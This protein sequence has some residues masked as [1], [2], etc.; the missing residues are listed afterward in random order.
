M[1]V[2]LVNPVWSFEGSTY[3]GCREPHLPLEFGYAQ[4]LLERAGHEVALVDGQLA[5]LSRAQLARQVWEWA[6]DLTVVT[7]APS[8]LFWRCAPPELRAPLL[9]AGDL[10]AGA[11]TERGTRRVPTRREGCYPPQWVAARMG[12]LVVVGPHGSSTPATTLRKLGADVVVLGECEEVLA[13]LAERLSHRSIADACREVGS[14][15]FWQDG[16]PCV[17]G[18]PHAS[19]MRSLPALHWPRELLSLHIHHHH[20]FEAPASGP[21]AEMEFSR[22]CPYRC[23]F[24]AKENFRNKYRKRPLPVVLE[25][26]DG[27]LSCGVQYVYFIDE[28]FLPDLELLGAV[29]ERREREP[30]FRFGMQ[31]RIDLWDE[32]ALELLGRAGCVSI[33]AGVESVSESGRESLNKRCK[34]S[35]SELAE[36]LIAARRHV[37]FVQANLLDAGTDDPALVEAW[38]ARLLEQGV[39]ANKPVPLYPYPGSPDYTR[40]WG[41]PDDVAWERSHA[42]YLEEA[43]EFSDIQEAEPLPLAVLENL[44]GEPALSVRPRN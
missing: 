5:G 42:A 26:L 11:P 37:P 22:G 6:P 9:T 13:A 14:V 21:G 41:E 24:C 43:R 10:R 7:T 31:T 34:L 15:C 1:R 39:W 25:E 36:R 17:V 33:E 8:Y 38:R 35:T 4:A 30:S 27:L 29:V 2:A 18:G 3:F 20:R 28:I 32:D 40:R 19:D 16:A 44:A 23:T 12:T